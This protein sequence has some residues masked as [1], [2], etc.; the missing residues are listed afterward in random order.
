MLNIEDFGAYYQENKEAIEQEQDRIAAEIMAQAKPCPL[1]GKKE[2]EVK[3][4]ICGCPAS[5]T[6]KCLPC[7]F[8]RWAML[9]KEALG[10]WNTRN[11][12]S[13]ENVHEMAFDL[14]NQAQSDGWQGS[15]DYTEE[16]IAIFINAWTE[17][18]G[19]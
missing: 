2:L 17:K 12:M 9:E 5:T 6:I 11:T 14:A 3:V 13:L 4:A 1:C 16:N 8:M 10:L 18:H 7:N 15:D 19:A